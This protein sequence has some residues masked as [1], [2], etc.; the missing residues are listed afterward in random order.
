MQGSVKR[1]RKELPSV[2]LHDQHSSQNVNEGDGIKEERR[3]GNFTSCFG[4]KKCIKFLV[5]KSEGK[6]ACNTSSRR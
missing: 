2:E 5:R 4:E 3:S 1:R 6:V